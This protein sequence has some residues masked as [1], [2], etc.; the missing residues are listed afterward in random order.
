[1]TAST[2]LFTHGHFGRVLAARWIGLP[3]TEG[4]H[5]QLG[6]A[7]LSIFGYDPHHPEGAVIAQWNFISKEGFESGN[8]RA[9]ERW[10]NEGGEIPDQPFQNPMCR[11]RPHKLP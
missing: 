4:E 8:S 3:V 11:P 7:S 6:T 2:A 5:F 10:E 1:M 9:I